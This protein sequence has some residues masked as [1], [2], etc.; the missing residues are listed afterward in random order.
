MR[1]GERLFISDT[2]PHPTHSLPPAVSRVTAFQNAEVWWLEGRKGAQGFVDTGL[3]SNTPEIVPQNPSVNLVQ[4]MG[5]NHR[6]NN[7]YQSVK[8]NLIYM[9]RLSVND[10]SEWSTGI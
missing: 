8:K 1:L 2:P 3:N 10:Q 5:T 6:P 4:F 7:Y 9:V